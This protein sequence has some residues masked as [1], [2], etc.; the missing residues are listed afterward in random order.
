VTHE[1]TGPPLTSHHEPEK[2]KGEDV[3]GQSRR[4]PRTHKK[5]FS[6]PGISQ[7]GPQGIANKIPKR[8]WNLKLQK[9][10]ETSKFSNGK[11]GRHRIGGQHPPSGQGRELNHGEMR[12]EV[13]NYGIVRPGGTEQS[14]P[15]GGRATLRRRRLLPELANAGSSA[16]NK[17]KKPGPFLKVGRAKAKEGG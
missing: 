2:N 16:K 4:K 15:G 7:R 6:T 8:P 11:A 1:H 10:Q 12:A 17:G 13:A 5:Q 3:T 9:S 14:D